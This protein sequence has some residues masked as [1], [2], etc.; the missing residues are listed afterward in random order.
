MIYNIFLFVSPFKITKTTTSDQVCLP[1]GKMEC[2]VADGQN[3][4]A[5]VA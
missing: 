3:R 4:S 5:I 2:P 1:L